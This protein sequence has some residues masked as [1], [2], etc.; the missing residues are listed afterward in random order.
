MSATVSDVG[1]TDEIEDCFTVSTSRTGWE[2]LGTSND[3][4]VE[5]LPSALGDTSSCLQW[6][7]H[8]NLPLEAAD[9]ILRPEAIGVAHH[10]PLIESVELL[11]ILAPGDGVLSVTYA[12]SL[13]RTLRTLLSSRGSLTGDDERIHLRVVRRRDFPTEGQVAMVMI[14]EKSPTADAN[15]W[16]QRF[17][18]SAEQGENAGC[19]VWRLMAVVPKA[20]CWT[21]PSLGRAGWK[22]NLLSDMGWLSQPGITLDSFQGY[23]VLRLK[24]CSRGP[25]LLPRR[26]GLVDSELSA[27]ASGLLPAPVS[28][29]APA[30]GPQVQPR[31]VQGSPKR[32]GIGDT[33]EFL[34]ES[35]SLASPNGDFRL[36]L[37]LQQVL[38]LGGHSGEGVY[39]SLDGRHVVFFQAVVRR[40]DWPRMQAIIDPFMAKHSSAYRHW[41]GGSGAPNLQVDATPM[42]HNRPW[43]TPRDTSP[44]RHYLCKN[45]FLHFSDSDPDFLD[46][47]QMTKALSVP[48]LRMTKSDR[49]R[50]KELPSEP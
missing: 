30:L 23:L 44:V 12:H 31:P 41:Y 22:W 7:Y 33:M 4:V 8:V 13:F 3:L 18:I 48:A 28:D 37:Y 49:F 20:V 5:I 11:R 29:P 36:N 43:V 1:F 14:Q 40:S 17:V 2:C 21:L 9:N 34:D 35:W 24:K 47:P 6:T 38:Q 27:T 46:T 45:T 15:S 19:S 25:P 26:A 50:M 42:F 10:C 16:R 32:G 39:D